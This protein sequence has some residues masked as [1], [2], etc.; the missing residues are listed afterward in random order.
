M[1]KSKGLIQQYHASRKGAKDHRLVN[2]ISVAADLIVK[3]SSG[4]Y[5]PHQAD[6][7]WE[8][9]EALIRRYADRRQNAQGN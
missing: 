3:L 2:T 9:I 7:V 4:F 8:M 5:E 1:S 6:D